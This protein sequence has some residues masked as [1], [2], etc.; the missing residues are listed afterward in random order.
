[1]KNDLA[2]L[3]SGNVFAH[4]INVIV[5]LVSAQL[6][7]PEAL[8]EIGVVTA[9]VAIGANLASGRYHLAIP[10]EH[11]IIRKIHL[12]SISII[13]SFFTAIGFGSVLIVIGPYLNA[14]NSFNLVISYPF[15]IFALIFAGSFFL[16]IQHFLSSI[17]R[18]KTIS[19]A[20][21]GKNLSGGVYQI[22]SGLLNPTSLN[23]L[24]AMLINYLTVVVMHF[25][26]LCVSIKVIK[27]RNHYTP[28]LLRKYLYLPIKSLPESILHTGTYQL[29]ILILAI[30]LDSGYMG[31]VFLT[32]QLLSLPMIV[33]GAAMGNLYIQRVASDVAINTITKQFLVILSVVSLLYYICIQTLV[34]AL[35]LLILPARWA[36]VSEIAPLLGL[37][38]C[39]QLIVS[40]LMYYFHAIKKS[41]IALNLQLYGF[42]HILGI[43]LLSTVFNREDIL[44]YFAIAQASFNFIVLLTL[45]FYIVKKK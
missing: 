12:L 8:A 14:N 6:Y 42:C 10:L 40:P 15:M 7:T 44:V 18:F 34:P 20:K 35:V 3:I 5:V 16:C 24:V 27:R 45:T 39:L 17:G 38:F 28:K 31:L 32:L 1:M 13:F 36:G 11:F 29:S 19:S 23:L 4:I 21:I 2:T 43:I 9:I 37:W 26:L 33:F 25:R 30:F 41:Q 22:I